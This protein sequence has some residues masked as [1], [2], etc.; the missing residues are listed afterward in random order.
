MID[1][2]TL[3]Y[4]PHLPRPSVINT[5]TRCDRH[6]PA[7][8]IGFGIDD[9]TDFFG[10]ILQLVFSIDPQTFQWQGRRLLA[11]KEKCLVFD[12]SECKSALEDE[13]HSDTQILLRKGRQTGSLL[14]QCNYN[15]FHRCAPPRNQYMEGVER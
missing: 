7:I 12:V 15:C 4:A 10:S 8:Y 3:L 2:I 1:H 9:L 13:A 6:Q 14:D 11:Y 5:V